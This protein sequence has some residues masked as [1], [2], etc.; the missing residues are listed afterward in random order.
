[1]TGATLF[2]RYS[3]GEN[4]V[5]STIV[6]VL[7]RLNSSLTERIL[8]RLTV[9]D[10]LALVTFINQPRGV[11]GVPDARI[12]ASFCYWVETKTSRQAVDEG[13]IARHLQT[14]KNKI[15]G[16]DARLLVLTPDPAIPPAVA[17]LQSKH[18]ELY[19]NNFAALVETVRAVL[20][21]SSFFP[22]DRELFLLRELVSFIEAEGL[23]SAGEDDVLVV[24]AGRLALDDYFR[25]NAYICQP[26]RTFRDVR[27]MAF[28]F[29][30]N[31]A[32]H[33]PLIKGHIES[34]NFSDAGLEQLAGQIDP[35]LQRLASDLVNRFVKDRSDRVGWEGK[36][37][38]LSAPDD[39]DTLTLPHEVENDKRGPGGQT[40]PFTQ[41]H[42]YVSLSKLEK[43]PRKTSD[44][45]SS[46]TPA[47]GVQP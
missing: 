40:I 33:V 47:S 14:V 2:S 39:P 4:R 44:L 22:T 6:A 15:Y 13:Q 19:W 1:V 11:T 8:Q 31:I 26:N 41:G 37:M 5:T 35:D 24:P 12:S 18:P 36:A 45:E 28:Y 23:I 16:D 30:G 27:R 10:N 25:Y 29:R 7:S 34:I 9:D 38:F 17:N 21:D 46:A 43:G 20:D 3:Q 42:R 32:R